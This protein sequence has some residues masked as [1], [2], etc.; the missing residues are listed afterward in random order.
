MKNGIT[1]QELL[2]VLRGALGFVHKV[3][4]GSHNGIGRE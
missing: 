3:T 2:S 4:R 1:L